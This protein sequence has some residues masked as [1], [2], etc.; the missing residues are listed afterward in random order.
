M[1]LL[2]KTPTTGYN[3][4][5]ASMRAENLFTITFIGG[6]LLAGA[7]FVN[8][9][10]SSAILPTAPPQAKQNILSPIKTESRFS[11]KLTDEIVTIP[12]N[13]IYK[14]DPETEIGTDTT[15]QEG[16]D[17]KT[18]KV[19][20]I[21]YYEGKEYG[22][23]IVGTETIPPEDKIISRGTKIIWRDLDTPDGTI[24]YWEKMHV[25]A[26]DY[27]SH[28]PGCDAWTATGLPQ[29]KGVIAVDPTVIKLGSK[30]YVPGYG[31]AIAGDT[32]GSIKGG[33]IDLGFTDTKTSGWHSRFVD[34]YILN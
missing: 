19:I 11:E 25:W 5:T 10:S 24:H 2:K 15:L 32:G 27:D 30:V 20:K 6:G 13:T 1:S 31:Q 7:I 8:Q 12:R 17:G 9:P 34:I 28:C 3:F 4:F 22:R 29:G 16:S 26:T 33:I 23:E 21:T 14:D 18:T